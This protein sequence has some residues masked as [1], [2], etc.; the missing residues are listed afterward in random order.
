MRAISHGGGDSMAIYPSKDQIEELLAGP[1]DTPVMMLNLLRYKPEAEG[2][3]AGVSGRESYA[4]Y[5]AEMQKIV[6]SYGG[7]IVW[8]GSVDSLV[9]GETDEE[10]HAVALVEY[11][12]RKVFVECIGDPRVQEIAPH[13]ANGLEMQWLVAA[14]AG[15]L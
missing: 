14:T 12:S 3:D 7:R 5:G 6:E 11:P 10:F 9:I 15:G 2:G 4:R 1:P 13:R 8:T